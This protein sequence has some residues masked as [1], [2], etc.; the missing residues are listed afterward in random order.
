MILANFCLLFHL[1]INSIDFTILFCVV[2]E[3]ERLNIYSGAYI[4]AM[5]SIFYTNISSFL[6]FP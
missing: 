5:N 1:E 6:C 3:K 4:F 2:K